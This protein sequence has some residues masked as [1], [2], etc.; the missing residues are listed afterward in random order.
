MA[1][2]FSLDQDRDV[3]FSQALASPQSPRTA[4]QHARAPN[5]RAGLT[6][7]T[8]PGDPSFLPAPKRLPSRLLKMPPATGSPSVTAAATA[9]ATT[10]S[11]GAY[12]VPR[13]NSHSANGSNPFPLPSGKPPSANSSGD[14]S[15]DTIA[16]LWHARTRSA[17]SCS[18]VS[19][20]GSEVALNKS[21]GQ[22]PYQRRP[23][24]VHYQPMVQPQATMPSQQ[25][26]TSVIDQHLPAPPLPV[27]TRSRRGNDSS[28]DLSRRSSHSMYHEYLHNEKQPREASSSSTFA[29]SS[30]SLSIQPQMGT[31]V[32]AA[33]SSDNSDGPLLGGLS[34][35]RPRIPDS[36]HDVHGR[37]SSHGHSETI[38]RAIG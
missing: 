14:R 23:S 37:S 28:E 18:T 12:F 21:F 36:P 22:P 7:E 4:L 35:P 17:R 30:S 16:A 15:N 38:G 26:P 1:G 10:G 27:S 34:P 9:A 25:L 3:L 6:D 24:V 5:S 11:A 8:I 29:S 13:R 33:G 2:R 20:A 19:Y 32:V 31:A